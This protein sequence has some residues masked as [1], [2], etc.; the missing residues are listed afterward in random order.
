M[1]LNVLAPAELT[2]LLLPALRA[3]GGTVVFVNSVQGLLPR[4]NSTIYATTKSA[5]R[6]LADTLRGEEPL[7]R[8]TSIYPGFVATGMQQALRQQEGRAYE[9]EKYVRPE[10]VAQVIAQVLATP[11]D[12]SITDLTLMHRPT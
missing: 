10:T 5:L 4:A 1:T 6:A 3:A 11:P 12:A 7:L 9:P 8:V 2:R